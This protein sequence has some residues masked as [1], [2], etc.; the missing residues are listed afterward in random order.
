MSPYIFKCLGSNTFPSYIILCMFYCT[1]LLYFLKSGLWCHRFPGAFFIFHTSFCLRSLWFLI[2][3]PYHSTVWWHSSALI[4]L[5]VFFHFTYILLPPLFKCILPTNGGLWFPRFHMYS[6]LNVQNK[7]C[8]SRSLTWD[9]AQRNSGSYSAYFFLI[10]F[11]CQFY[12]SI[13]LYSSA[14]F[15]CVKLPYIH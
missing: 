14:Q 8:E 1:L 13:F 7:I 11:I 15:S 5:P 2:F 10:P 12:G 9:R 4:I 6:M 3:H